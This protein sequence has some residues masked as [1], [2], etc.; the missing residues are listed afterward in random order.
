MTRELRL[1]VCLL[2]VGL[3][4]L[5]AKPLQAVLLAIAAFFVLRPRRVC[6]Q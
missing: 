2:S 6:W 5:A 1:F 4:V 3:I